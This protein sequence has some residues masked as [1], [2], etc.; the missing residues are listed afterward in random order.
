[1]VKAIN[2]KAKGDFKNKMKKKFNNT[3]TKS[4]TRSFNSNNP[5]RKAPA[6]SLF[7]NIGDKGKQEHF[8]SKSKIKLLN[9]YNE[10][11]DKLFF[12]LEKLCINN[13]LNLLELSQIE[14][15][16]VTYDL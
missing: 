15:G 6:G 1:M 13:Q 11:A 2:S 3:K 10:K 4:K 14:N 9:M 7:L 12:K 16:S 5:D 8:R